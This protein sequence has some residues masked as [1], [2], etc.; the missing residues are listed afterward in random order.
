MNR[1]DYFASESGQGAAILQGSSEEI[2]D[3]LV[4]LLRAKG[5]I[6]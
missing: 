5:R 1:R 6:K 2:L 3:R 4:D